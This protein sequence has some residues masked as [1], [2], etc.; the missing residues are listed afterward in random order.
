MPKEGWKMD[1]RN[2]RRP[3]P[4]WGSF[5]HGDQPGYVARH[6]VDREPV[7]DEDLAPSR[8]TRGE[9]SDHDDSR[10]M[11]DRD[12]EGAARWEREE[13]RGRGDFEDTDFRTQ[14]RPGDW[15]NTWDS[16][17]AR[18]G[19]ERRF[20]AGVPGERERGGTD[21]PGDERAPGRGDD[22]SRGRRRPWG[23]PR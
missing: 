15:D 12:R 21:E 17:A 23:G 16:P 8:D 5:L 14:G 6:H 2:E 1:R 22:S 10:F 20:Y 4:R 19:E 9:R 13:W 7:Y 11:S 3:S 18:F